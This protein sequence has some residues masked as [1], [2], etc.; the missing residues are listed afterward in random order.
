MFQGQIDSIEGVLVLKGSKRR[1]AEAKLKERGLDQYS[2]AYDAA[3]V[4][5]ST[6]G[7][8]RVP[9]AKDLARYHWACGG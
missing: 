6:L 9:A 4:A 1:Y 7:N 8:V 5:G 2:G 3:S